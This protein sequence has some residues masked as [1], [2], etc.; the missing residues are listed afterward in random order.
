MLITSS[1]MRISSKMQGFLKTW[2]GRVDSM[3]VLVMQA[4]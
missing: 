3:S 1:E 2:P 4:V